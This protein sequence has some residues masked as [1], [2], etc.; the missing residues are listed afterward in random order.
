MGK[1]KNLLQTARLLD[2]SY[3]CILKRA[4]EYAAQLVQRGREARHKAKI[5]G[6]KAR[7]NA[8]WQSFQELCRENKR[9]T[10]KRVVM[11]MFQRTGKRRSTAL[12]LPREARELVPTGQLR[13][14]I[15]FGN[16]I[17]AT[18]DPKTGE[19]CGVSVYLATKLAALIDAP[20][21]LILYDGAGEV[22]AGSERDEW[23]V[24]FVARDPLRGKEI[25][26]TRPYLLI[27]GAYLFPERCQRAMRY[28][29]ASGSSS[30]MMPLVFR[31]CGCCQGVSW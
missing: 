1:T 20:L 30:N 14:A 29:Q 7:F 13:P 22:V 4:P 24:A 5:E 18:R 17:L 6:E 12:K 9:P 19:P 10:G 11:R 16:P 2:V 27:E 31:G 26:Q 28:Q 8:Y 21:Q 23:D 15:N 25:E 3:T